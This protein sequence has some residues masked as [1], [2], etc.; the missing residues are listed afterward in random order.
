[1]AQRAAHTL[2]ST[3][4]SLGAQP[5]SI[6]CSE[7]EE[8]SHAGQPKRTADLLSQIEAIYEQTEQALLHIQAGDVGAAGVSELLRLYIQGLA[9]LTRECRRREGFLKKRDAGFEHP[10]VDDRVI[11]VAGDIQHAQR[12]PRRDMR[13]RDQ[14]APAHSGHHHIG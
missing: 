11:G 14:L 8:I 3:S 12:W 5:L 10:V 9:H 7:L 2:K 1:M 13:L 4:A 6:R